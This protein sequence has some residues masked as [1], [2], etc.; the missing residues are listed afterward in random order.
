MS[1]I[2][3]I[4]ELQ[5]KVDELQKELNELKEQEK[6]TESGGVWRPKLGERYFYI[7]PNGEILYDTNDDTPTDIMRFSIGNVFRT[8]EEAEF[9]VEKLKA[10]AELKVFAEP[11]DRK[12]DGKNKHWCIGY[13]VEDDRIHVG[14]WLAYKSNEVYFETKEKAQQAVDA[15]G[16]DRIKKY[17]LEV[18]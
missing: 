14:H 6:E 2:K 16:M 4:E 7:S 1:K 17:Y 12:W 8:K 5:K 18:E 13:D 15:V 3:E 10:L 11:K 9:A